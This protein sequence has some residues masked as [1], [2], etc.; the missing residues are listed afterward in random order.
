MASL[1]A[2]QLLALLKVY[3]SLPVEPRFQLAVTAARHLGSTLCTTEP[4][5]EAFLLSDCLYQCLQQGVH[6]QQAATAVLDA[7]LAAAQS[8]GMTDSDAAARAVV[9]AQRM[10]CGT[11]AAVPTLKKLLVRAPANEELMQ[12]VTA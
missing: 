11:H 4:K 5:P 2:Q 6:D 9:C 7:V 3:N 8:G 1:S 12:Q 10:S